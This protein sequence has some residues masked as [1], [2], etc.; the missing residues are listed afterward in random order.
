MKSSI[1][2]NVTNSGVW[3]GQLVL[4]P[5]AAQKRRVRRGVWDLDVEWA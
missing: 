5:S 2:K 1:G 3:G 4:G